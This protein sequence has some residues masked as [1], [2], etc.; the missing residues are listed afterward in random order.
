MGCAKNRVAIFLLLSSC[1]LIT[2]LNAELSKEARSKG[3]VYLD[4]VDSTILISPRYATSE[5]FVGAPVDGYTRK[6]RIV[7]TKVAAEALK[8]VQ[9]ALASN[10]YSLVVYDAYRPQRAVD[11]FMRWSTDSKAQ[12]KKSQ[13]YPYVNKA[14]VFALGYVAE[15]S[16]HSRG[17]TVD[18]TLIKKSDALHAILVKARTLENGE[19]I[20]FLD[21]GTVDMGTS[22]DLFDT[23]SNYESD[24]ID[25]TSNMMRTYLRTV[26]KKYGFKSSEQEWWHF[27][28]NNEPYPVGQDSSYFNFPIE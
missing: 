1:F 16:G 20:E 18:V 13:Y 6:D 4:E 11:H 15:R 3:F 2:A 24:K 23:A 9:A 21:D 10:G 25:Q 8:K 5:N 17:S 7:L 12:E 14:D 28:L 27:T 22:F 19:I 26:M